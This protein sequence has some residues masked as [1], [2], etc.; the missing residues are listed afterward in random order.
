MSDNEPERYHEW[1]QWKMKQEDKEENNMNKF[2]RIMFEP[3]KDVNVNHDEM[4]KHYVM[5]YL[6]G[7][8][9]EWAGAVA[10]DYNRKKAEKPT[11]EPLYQV[12]I[13]NHTY[14]AKMYLLEY[15]KRNPLC[16]YYIHV[17]E[18]NRNYNEDILV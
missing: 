9:T 15:I 3:R 14:A 4:F 2:L 12:L 1:I 11:G 8:D 17:N 5:N 10:F 13:R 7:F 6:E 16:G 18:K